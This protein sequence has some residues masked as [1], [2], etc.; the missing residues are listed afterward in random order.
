[1]PSLM[2]QQK[3][4]VTGWEKWRH[5]SIYG[6]A[7]PLPNEQ[8]PSALNGVKIFYGIGAVRGVPVGKVSSRFIPKGKLLCSLPFSF[9]CLTALSEIICL[10][11]LTEFQDIESDI[12]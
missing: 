9:Y 6:K 1:M 12:I 2:G 3:G 4:G 11:C 7:R 8:G 10:P 5:I